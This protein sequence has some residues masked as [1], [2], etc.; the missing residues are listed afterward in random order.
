MYIV[1][2]LN[3]N[4]FFKIIL[5]NNKTKLIYLNNS[6]YL[7]ADYIFKILFGM[8]NIKCIYKKIEANKFY[9]KN[10][11]I[12]NDLVAEYFN[13][14]KLNNIEDKYIKIRIGNLIF[15]DIWKIIV[16]YNFAKLYSPKLVIL[17]KPEYINIF[18]NS[19]LYHF[20]NI[21]FY[22]NFINLC[23]YDDIILKNKYN[24]FFKTKIFIRLIINLFTF[25][26]FSWSKKL[27]IENLFYIHPVN[28]NR[29]N[30]SINKIISSF[31]NNAILLNNKNI[32]LNNINYSYKRI[33]FLKFPKLLFYIFYKVHIFSRYKISLSTKIILLNDFIDY[34]YLKIMIIKF[35]PDFLYTNYESSKA[36]L[37]QHASK[38][39]K[40]CV[41]LSSSFSGG[42][43]PSEYEFT[44]YR[45]ISDIYFVWGKFVSNIYRQSNDYSKFHIFSGYS[46]NINYIK[47]L[48]PKEKFNKNKTITLFDTSVGLDIATSSKNIFETIHT[49]SKLKA[50]YKI[51]IYLKT[52]KNNTQYLSKIKKMN[53]F[54][55]IDHTH[56]S[57]EFINE[58]DCVLGFCLSSPVLLASSIGKDVIFLDTNMNI[59]K[60]YHHIF[61]NCIVNSSNELRDMLDKYINN[62]CNF[63]IADDYKKEINFFNDFN[64]QERVLKYLKLIKKNKN[65]NKDITIKNSNNYYLRDYGH[66]S[67]INFTK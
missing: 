37:I 51:N 61:K 55:K 66:N 60:N 8:L 64:G 13:T 18:K 45:K 41:S 7:F 17:N 39:I 63:K 57:L 40:N 44:H 21:I 48:I 27:K 4:S 19:K 26:P 16:M 35:Q 14:H 2:S 54:D 12:A 58:S 31:S 33:N 49:L 65:K 56:A 22:N 24:N 42:D 1:D 36:L 52:K 15:E 32:K 20:S 10:I 43:F 3:F 6:K 53:L 34:F 47:N 46:G 9:K 29:K 50:K 11:K 5:L 23:N 38:C 59:D 30:V 25:T 62:K 28:K 67:I